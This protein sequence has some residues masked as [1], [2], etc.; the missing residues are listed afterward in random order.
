[1]GER[2]RDGSDGGGDVAFED[3]DGWAG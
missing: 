2:G 1:V 3:D